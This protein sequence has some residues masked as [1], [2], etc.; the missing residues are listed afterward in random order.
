MHWIEVYDKPVVTTH[1]AEVLPRMI[2]GIH[3]PYPSGERAAKVLGHMAN[4]A[5]M[6][7]RG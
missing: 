2:E 5:E 1:F 4:Y 6:L 3:H 7:K